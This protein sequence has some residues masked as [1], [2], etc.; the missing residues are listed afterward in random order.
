MNTIYVKGSNGNDNEIIISFFDGKLVIEQRI[1]TGTEI[2][3][4]V[5]MLDKEQVSFL[6]EMIAE[7]MLMESANEQV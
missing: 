6:V 4:D 2:T 3:N 7:N 1:K 5:V